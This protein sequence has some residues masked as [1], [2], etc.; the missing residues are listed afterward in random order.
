MLYQ[1]ANAVVRLIR[2]YGGLTEKELAAAMGKRQSRNLIWRWEHES[3]L[4]S[5]KQEAIL[6]KEA[7]LTRV[8]FVEIMCKVLSNFLGLPVMIA[9]EGQNAWASPLTRTADLYDAYRDK[10]DPEVQTRIEEALREARK[11]AA[12]ADRRCIAFEQE[13]KDVIVKALAV[14]GETLAETE[15]N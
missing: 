6:V 1:I 4:P 8:A 2:E 13:I 14:R 7:H 5:P 11:L 3:H 12:Q 9:A 10:L 15:I